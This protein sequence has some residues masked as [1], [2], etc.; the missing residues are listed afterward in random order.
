[1]H[2]FD[3]QGLKTSTCNQ[4]P[5]KV[6]IDDLGRRPSPY[7]HRDGIETLPNQ[8]APTSCAALRDHPCALP[9]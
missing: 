4:R 9:R 3:L 2:P 7:N 6:I 8:L 5:S 1:M